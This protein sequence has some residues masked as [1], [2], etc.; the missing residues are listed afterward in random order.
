MLRVLQLETKKILYTIKISGA[1]ANDMAFSSDGKH[2]A[3]AFGNQVQI[4]TFETMKRTH[5]Y[6]PSGTNN[7]F[8]ITKLKWHPNP[9]LL[10][11]ITA[12]LQNTIAVFDYILNKVV[13]ISETN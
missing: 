4:F 3:C 11:I 6:Y 12:D 1:F 2:L 7:K 8:V 10:Q 9:E 5:S 13:A